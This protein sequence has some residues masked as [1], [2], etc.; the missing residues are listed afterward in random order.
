[1]EGLSSYQNV[2][3]VEGVRNTFQRRT[4]LFLGIY[5]KVE[6]ER[7]EMMGEVDGCTEEE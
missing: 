4:K 5:S 2:D 6:R 1:M 7:V 3:K